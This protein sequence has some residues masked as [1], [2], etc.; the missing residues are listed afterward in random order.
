MTT[1]ISA[2]QSALRSALTE[3]GWGI[4]AVESPGDWWCH[5]RW[6]LR[7]MWAP[8]EREAFISFLV[9]PQ[10]EM[11]ELHSGNARVWAAAAS[12]APLSRWQDAPAQGMVTFARKWE[13]EVPKLVEYL[14]TLRVSKPSD[15]KP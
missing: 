6:R 2:H 9:E 7:S 3:R 10:S 15:A 1:H 4:V 5:E 11:S 13:A 8:R 12:A 14:A